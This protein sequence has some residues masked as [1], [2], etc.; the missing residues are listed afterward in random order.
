VGIFFINY[1]RKDSRAEFKRWNGFFPRA[2]P[3][4]R[5]KKKFGGIIHTY[6]LNVTRMIKEWGEAYPIGALVK[7]LSNVVDPLKE[8]ILPAGS[9]VTIKDCEIDI[10]H[11]RKG[12][13]WILCEDSSKELWNIRPVCLMKD[14]PF[15]G[16]KGRFR[17]LAQDTEQEKMM[18]TPNGEVK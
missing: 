1:G 17:I 2:M 16:K 11:V 5:F 15:T 13:T 7:T 4:F 12:P 8:K 10:H 18:K 3:P 6:G 9:Y 14:I